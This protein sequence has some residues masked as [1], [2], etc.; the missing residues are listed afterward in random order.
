MWDGSA[1]EVDGVE[2]SGVIGV[3]DD[4]DAAILVDTEGAKR[5]GLGHRE[6][7]EVMFNAPGLIAKLSQWRDQLVRIVIILL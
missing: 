2:V 7:S 5:G 3:K 6:L 4:V 1:V